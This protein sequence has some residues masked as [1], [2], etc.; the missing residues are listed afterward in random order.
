[1][2]IFSCYKDK[3]SIQLNKGKTINVYC[4]L[5]IINNKYVYHT[6]ELKDWQR[7]IP[8]ISQVVNKTQGPWLDWWVSSLFLPS[9][10]YHWWPSTS[11]LSSPPFRY[12]LTVDVL[13]VGDA[14]ICQTIS[15]AIVIIL[16]D[17]FQLGFIGKKS[18]LE[19]QLL[20]SLHGR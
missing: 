19:R 11:G 20:H 4:V 6:T 5:F 13:S 2:D 7:L 1:M 10:N 18:D 17:K 9:F 14:V 15:P 12:T 16:H 8:Q 3:K